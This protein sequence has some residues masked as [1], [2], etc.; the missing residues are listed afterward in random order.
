MGMIAIHGAYYTLDS[1][2][3]HDSDRLGATQ[4][5][6]RRTETFVLP[7]SQPIN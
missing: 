7:S 1:E 6:L 5:G 3:K 4:N 2:V